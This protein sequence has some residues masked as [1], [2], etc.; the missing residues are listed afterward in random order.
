LYRSARTFKSLDQ[1]GVVDVPRRPKEPK[2]WAHC[3]GC[4]TP[5]QSD[6]ERLE[7]RRTRHGR[8]GPLLVHRQPVMDATLVSPR[9][10]AA[11]LPPR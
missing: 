8:C 2:A 11:G 3:I 6:E 9:A 5:E 10:A 4:K 7:V 1:Q